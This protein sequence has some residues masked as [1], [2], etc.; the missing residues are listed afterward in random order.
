MVYGY[1]CS[2]NIPKDHILWTVLHHRSDS[3]IVLLRVDPTLPCMTTGSRRAVGCV[4]TLAATCCQA[5]WIYELSNFKTGKVYTGSCIP[6]LTNQCANVNM[7]LNGCSLGNAYAGL[8]LS[9][10]DVAVA[11]STI[12]CIGAATT[13]ASRQRPGSLL[14]HRVPCFSMD[15]S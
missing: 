10:A 8:P 7:Y 5:S 4:V 3:R 9:A 13:A 6:N 15:I 1:P 2:L 12:S 14:R 11:F